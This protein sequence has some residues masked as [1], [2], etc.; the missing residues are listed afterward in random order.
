MAGRF[1]GADTVSQ[2]WGNIINKVEAISEVPEA[3]WGTSPESVLSPSGGPDKT[4]TRRAGIIPDRMP[5]VSGLAIDRELVRNLDPMHRLVLDVG[6][7]AL[8]SC[9]PDPANRDRTG[10][11]LAAIALP[12]DSASLLTRQVIGGALA[13]QITGTALP[14][15]ADISANRCLAARVTGYPA[16]LLARG[17]GLGAGSLTLDAACASSLYAVKL[18]CDELISGRTDTMLAG[19]VSRPDV[20]YTQ[21]GFTQLKALSPNGRCAPFDTRADGLVVG[22]G[23]GILV[24]KRLDD[25]RRDRDTIIG[26]IRGLGISNDLD[27]NLLAPASEGQVRAMT[28]AY[29]EAGWLPD[30][31]DLIECHGAGTPVG[32]AVEL[33]SMIQL[34]KGSSRTPGSCAIGSIKSMIGH[35]LT[36]AGAAG[37]IK[38]LLAMRHRVLPPSLNYHAPPQSSPILDSPFRV[39]TEP[40]PWQ[41]RNPNIP[42]RAAI[43]AF[44]F[45]GINAHLLLEEPPPNDEDQPAPESA[46]ESVSIQIEERPPEPIAIVGMGAAAGPADTLALFQR[47]VFNEEAA[48]NPPPKNRWKGCDPAAERWLEGRAGRGAYMEK[49]TIHAGEF[50]IPPREIPDILPQHLLMLKV[51]AEAMA[52]AGIERDRDQVRMGAIVGIDFDMDATNFHLRWRS[53]TADGFVAGDL[54]AGEANHVRNALSAPLTADRTVGALGSMVASRIAREFRLGG[55]S[56]VISDGTASG[57]KALDLAARWLR[58]DDADAILVGAVDLCGDVRSVLMA[59]RSR[60]M[61]KRDAVLPFDTSADGTLPGDGAVAVVVKRLE[62]AIADGDRIYAVLRGMGTASGCEGEPGLVSR[63]AY[64]GSLTE[65]FQH[66][67]VSPFSIGL[68]EAHGSGDPTEDRVE[69]EAIETFFRDTRGGPQEILAVSS[70]KSAIGHM[71]AASGLASIVKTALCLY[72]EILPPMPGFTTSTLFDATSV[73]VHVPTKPLYWVRNRKDGPRRA[74]V[75]AMTTDGSC[76]HAILEAPG[77]EPV[78]EDLA[79][80]I[81]VERRRPVGVGSAGLFVVAGDTT[82]ELLNELKVFRSFVDLNGTSG[83]SMARLAATWFQSGI[84]EKRLWSALVASEIEDLAHKTDTLMEAVSGGYNL[85]AHGI[86]YTPEPVGGSGELAFVFPGSGNHYLGMGRELGVLWPDIFRDLN[87]IEDDLRNQMRPEA[88]VPYRMSWEPGWEQDAYAGL[89]SDPVNLICSQ[90]LFGSATTRMA[91]ALGIHPTAAIG[92]SLGESAALFALGA[93][94][95]RGDMLERMV[96]SDLFTKDIAGPYHAVR[97]AWR[98]EATRDI[99]WLTAVINRPAP[100]IRQALSEADRIR[101]LIANTP[102]ECVIGG[103]KEDVL[104]FIGRFGCDAVLVDGVVAVHCD[105]LEPVKEA[106]RQLHF[107]PVSEPKGVR[108][109]SSASAKTYRVTSEAAADA[110]LSNAR[111]GFDFPAVIHQAHQDGV[112]VFLEMGPQASCSRMIRQILTDQ[113]HLAVSMG[114]T[115]K[116]GLE[117]LLACLARLIAEGVPVDLNA[118]YGGRPETERLEVSPAHPKGPSTDRILGDPAIPATVGESSH[119]F[120]TREHYARDIDT[121]ESRPGTRMPPRKPNPSL[122]DTDPVAG[123]PDRRIAFLT[124]AARATAEAHDLFLDLSRDLAQVLSEGV[125]LQQ[126]LAHAMARHAGEPATSADTPPPG[127]GSEAGRPPAFDRDMCLEFAIGSAAKVLGP[128]FARVDT[129]PIRVRLPDEPLM[130]VDRILTVEGEKASLSSGRIVTEHDV[131]PGAWYL[132]GGKAPVCISVEAGQADLFMCAYLGIDLELKGKRAYRLLDA[133]V[134]FHRGLPEPGDVIRYD[135][136]IEKFVRQGDSWLFF[137][138][139]DGFIGNEPLITMT[140]GCAGFFTDAEIRNSGGILLTDDEKTPVPGK[141]LSDWHHP[142][143]MMP[144]R[145]SSAQL[146]ALRQGRPAECF[147]AGFKNVTVPE[148]LRLPGGRMRLID[149]VVDLDP[150]GGRCGLGRIRAE[151]DIHPG[152]WFLTCHFVD[153]MVMPGTLMYEC[154]AHTLRV[155]LQRMGWIADMPGAAYEPVIGTKAVLKCRGP[156]TPR[157]RRVL[158]EVELREIGFDPEPYAIADANMYADGQFIVRFDGM[159][160]QLSGTTRQTIENFWDRRNRTSDPESALDRSLDRPIYTRQQILEFA[161]GAPSKAFGEAYTVFDNDRFIAR[162]P[163]RPYSFMDRVIQADAEPRVLKPGGWFVSE[164]DMRRDHWYFKANRTPALPF[165]V[166]LEAVLQPCGF[167]AAYVGTA[168]TSERDLHFR[169]LGGTATLHRDLVPCDETL[170][171]QSRMTKVATAGD[172]VI[173]DFEFQAMIGEELIYNGTTNFGFFTKEALAQ[174]IGIRDSDAFSDPAQLPG[175]DIYRFQKMPPLT[176]DDPTVTDDTPRSFP[177]AALRMIDRIDTYRPKGGHH[178][179]GYVRGTKLVDPDAW[180]FKAHFLQDPVCPGSLGL[181]SFL[182][183]LKYVANQRW[184][185]LDATHRIT[186]LTGRAHSWQYR[187]QILQTNRIVDVEAHISD[188]EQEPFPTLV[189]EG[190]LRVDGLIIYSMTDFGIRLVPNKIV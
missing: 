35:L 77:N 160:M 112:R 25:A 98:I 111:F 135:I 67:G 154:C 85:M 28:A 83:G 122:P 114:K 15:A 34:W 29:A 174:Q 108:F 47:R 12:T 102:G 64:M 92:Y 139:F 190:A 71:G 113:P 32:D 126:R 123:D 141:G 74:C 134:S 1:P 130:L 11:V 137:F 158:Y 16:A 89:V 187:G 144:E 10:V 124:D 7:S 180:F 24:L 81:M 9:S 23:A 39:Q 188:V 103:I 104:D 161:E 43:S 164:F 117:P 105:V 40:E 178:G 125:E 171:M 182:Q 167:I 82:E 118:L 44:G 6:K 145:Y 132:D 70:A 156:V 152:D 119:S 143:P 146:D 184:P 153:D 26:V 36:A 79:T 110:I 17:L 133:S 131:L 19:G 38:V 109:Y 149:R 57:L 88:T 49:L 175:H 62:T 86:H 87:S 5:D 54:A 140:D 183:L 61:S 20:L 162:L 101:L 78:T 60:P 176:P 147:G 69:A 27:G 41:Q 18:A 150:S 90:V 75:A 107:L 46:D 155:F 56:F 53:L 179:L 76:T 72:Q 142:V 166:L 100:S 31:V 181:E 129:Y 138:H 4:F 151:A 116:D 148:G 96:R 127:S 48:W 93:W 163:S 159:S 165:C 173:Q 120:G 106:Y 94:P 55:P 169:N 13:S 84:S 68:Y 66:A 177:A 45:G 8:D 21:I 185:E 136:E 186:T 128:E 30:G 91:Q 50:R 80:R 95:R 73:H 37:M 97:E 51:S 63:S 115:G 65:A 33:N 2:F 58:R 42:R 168:L 99:Q 121:A 170:T 52:D 189:A 157:T 59:D 3:R 22:E 172:M 14:S